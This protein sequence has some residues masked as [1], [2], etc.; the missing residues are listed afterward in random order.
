MWAARWRSRSTLIV[1]GPANQGPSGP[2]WCSANCTYPANG[3]IFDSDIILNPEYS[4][5]TTGV[6]GTHDLEAVLL[7][8]LGHSLSANHT[9]LLGA[10]MF[11]FPT[12]RF[13]TTDDLAFVN[14]TYPLPSGGAALGTI[15]GTVSVAGAEPVPV[16]YALLTAFDTAAGVT[17]GGIPNPDGTYAFDVPAGTY[18]L[19]AEPLNGVVPINIYLT[20]AQASLAAAT[21]FHTTLYNG[22]LTGPP[23]GTATANIA[24]TSG[25]SSLTAPVVAVTPV[26]GTISTGNTGGPATVASGQAVDLVLSGAGFDATLD[27]FEFRVLRPGNIAEAWVRS[28]RSVS[29]VQRISFTPADA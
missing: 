10:S 21:K 3:D 2:V 29:D 7:H 16:P 24:V 1:T 8:E 12:Q 4:F 25:A 28:R 6:A 18:Q 26:N 11:Q 5:S 15:A 27:R 19:Y 23:S 14:S 17:V 13:L 9:G 22:T 20:S